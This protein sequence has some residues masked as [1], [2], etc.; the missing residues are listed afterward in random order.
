MGALGIG[1]ISPPKDAQALLAEFRQTGRQGPFEEIVR[2]YG[3]MVFHACM[4]VT[5][6][7]HDAEDA[8]QAVFLALAVQAKT[9]A[10]IRCVGPWLQQ[11]AHRLALDLRRSRQRR[12]N[13]EQLHGAER[14]LESPGLEAGV[15]ADELRQIV[16]EE[17]H[18]LP[19]KYRLPLILHYFGGLSR[20][21]I[22]RELKC[23][24]AT[25][26]VRL[27][28]ARKLLGDRLSARGMGAVSGGALALVLGNV[29]HSAVTDGMIASMCE[30]AGH[31]AASGSVG[32][33]V[34][35]ARVMGL[36]QG[37]GRA[38]VLAKCKGLVAIALLAVSAVAAGAQVV[39]RVR[40]LDLKLPIP[41]DVK[42]ILRPRF[43]LRPRVQGDPVEPLPDRPSGLAA[44]QAGRGDR[45]GHALVAPPGAPLVLWP[46]RILPEIG[47]NWIS[48]PSAQGITRSY[49]MSLAPAFVPASH[50]ANLAGGPAFALDS[51]VSS[52]QGGVSSRWPAP[53][54]GPAVADAAPA[55]TGDRKLPPEKGLG[56]RHL[57]RIPTLGPG[58]LIRSELAG[59][60]IQ[61][62]RST[63]PLLP[64]SPF[65]PNP[66]SNTTPSN[67]H[68]QLVP[69]AFLPDLIID[70][71]GGDAYVRTRPMAVPIGS[72]AAFVL[73]V[74]DRYTLTR[75]AGAV[76]VG[77]YA[78]SIAAGATLGWSSLTNAT[79]AWVTHDE[80]TTYA[81]TN[82]LDSGPSA[83][84]LPDSMSRVGPSLVGWGTLQTVRRLDQNGQ[85]I[86]DGLGSD[87][88]LDLSAAQAIENT[89]DNPRTNGFNGWFAQRRGKLVLPSIP[90]EAGSHTY[91]WGESPA[92]PVLDLINSMR[93]T[94][95][96]A[97][98]D[99]SMT[100]SLLAPDRADVPSLPNPRTIVGLWQLD[101]LEADSLSVAIRYDDI[102]AHQLGVDESSL[103]LWGFDGTWR[104]LT[105]H[106]S[107]NSYDHLISAD[108]HPVTYLAVVG[109]VPEPGLLSLM[110]VAAGLLLARR[111]R[112]RE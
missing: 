15:G 46:G 32:A 37:A 44:A 52:G 79:D 22:A 58:G 43:D 27:H 16:A 68:T 64:G 56:P 82:G 72:T 31:M 51:T 84:T 19:G 55:S 34:V 25:L 81:S 97:H 59:P 70:P 106:F 20:E 83:P 94:L 57:D 54:G 91:T 50:G 8:T 78:L 102:L 101:G 107:L 105:D 74:R 14:G 1:S 28:R 73:G 60:G 112:P 104:P 95:H 69:V 53:R 40:P 11:V 66:S 41:N 33:G 30:A 75:S 100:L 7:R 88:T 2:R 47:V 86:A 38:L 62:E 42:G 98:A 111:T 109:S 85:V 103:T 23:K 24:P 99:G 65:V 77:E 29:I 89:R 108:G 6:N 71:A 90:F 92:D 80:A 48:Q 67:P 96:G 13:R 93:I 49:A 18:Q 45:R 21:E 110:A 87:Q 5:R 3:G 12:H 9:G 10:D 36:A 26:G 76:P 61:P 17:L 39:S 35:S 4:Q 63:V